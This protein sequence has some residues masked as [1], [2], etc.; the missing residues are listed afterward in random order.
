MESLDKLSDYEKR[1]FF[2]AIS[3]FILGIITIL[4]Y[5]YSGSSGIF[6]FFAIITIIVGLYMA[7][8]ISNEE[9]VLGQRKR[10]KK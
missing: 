5:I 1:N 10:S 9:N 6:V 3:M 7:L 2:I 4:T 8:R